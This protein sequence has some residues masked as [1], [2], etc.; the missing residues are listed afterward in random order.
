[1]RN[2]REENGNTELHLPENKLFYKYKCFSDDV[3]EKRPESEIKHCLSLNSTESLRVRVTFAQ[4]GFKIF[5][6][7]SY[8]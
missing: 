2:K 3:T 8:K 5:V 1:M 6:Q 7:F 4:K